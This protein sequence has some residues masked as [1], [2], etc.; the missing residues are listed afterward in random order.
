VFSSDPNQGLGGASEDAD[1]RIQFVAERGCQTLHRNR[2][3]GEQGSF[4]GG[5]RLAFGLDCLGAGTMDV[6]P[7]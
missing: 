2:A 1:R 6:D 5:F 7:V 3:F 4:G